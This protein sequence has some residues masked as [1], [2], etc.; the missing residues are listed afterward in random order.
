MIA[1][2]R[3]LLPHLFYVDTREE[4][5]PLEFTHASYLVRIYPPLRSTGPLSDPTAAPRMIELP[6]LASPQ[7]ITGEVLFDGAP[8]IAADLLQFDFVKHEFDRTPETNDPSLDDIYFVANRFIEHV[9]TLSRSDHLKPLQ[10]ISVSWGLEY[11]HDDGSRLDRNPSLIRG[12]S[13]L[14]FRTRDATAITRDSWSALRA[15]PHD[16]RPSTADQL[17]LD[18]SSLLPDIGPALVLANTAIEVAISNALERVATGASIDQ[19][20]WE[21]INDRDG[22]YRKEPS[23]KERLTILA[24]ALGG[25]SLKDEQSLWTLFCELRDARNA[26]A[27]DGTATLQKGRVA[28]SLPKAAELVSGAVGIV[29][30]IETLLPPEARRPRLLTTTTIERTQELGTVGP[31]FKAPPE[32]EDT[33]PEEK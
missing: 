3:V 14:A 11:L 2:T 12:R 28:V 33:A 25:R 18:A 19:H 22:D 8:T 10:G 5:P 27:H 23:V 7:P 13:G 26:F 15:L 17:L 9:R 16:F 21:W 32:T 24:K 29:D 30:W 6:A 20:L 4:L 31:A 1:R